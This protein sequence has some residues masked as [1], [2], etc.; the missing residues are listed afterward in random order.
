M[1]MVFGVHYCQLIIPLVHNK[2]EIPPV[3]TSSSKRFS[4]G[5]LVTLG[6]VQSLHR[7]RPLQPYN[8]S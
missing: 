1:D 4:S 7:D 3:I 8:G 6:G 2:I 5:G